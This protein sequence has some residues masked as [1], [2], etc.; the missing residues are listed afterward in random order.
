MSLTRCPDGTCVLIMPRFLRRCEGL[1]VDG[2]EVAAAGVPAA[3][4]GKAFAT[5]SEAPLWLTN[6]LIALYSALFAGAVG[7]LI[8]QLRRRKRAK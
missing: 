2:A 3:G 7:F 1:R 8:R 6:A 5:D 4:V